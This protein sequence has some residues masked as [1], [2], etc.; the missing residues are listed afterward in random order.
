MVLNEGDF[1]KVEYRAWR[2][3]DNALVYTTDVEEAKKAGIFDENVTYGPHLV[4]VGKG[5]V[6]K[7]IDAAMRDMDVGQTKKI[8]LEPKDAF[9]ERNPNL[10]RVLPVSDL[11]RRD[12]NPYVGMTLDVDGVMATVKSITSGRVVIDANHRFAGEKMIYEVKIVEKEETDEKK[13]A[14]LTE[15][16]EVKQSS[17]AVN[18]DS[19]KI[20]VKSGANRFD[21]RYFVGKE[22]LVKDL[23][24]YFGRINKV[25]IEE[26]H[27]RSDVE[28]ESEQKQ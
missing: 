27:N 20:L 2:A 14:A 3:A 1:V 6:L 28:K 26:E 10:V 24:K 16:H 9:G 25:I 22:D 7:G 23:M 13:I 12:I 17:V 21:A 8:E 15:Y 19:V 11:K 4:I 18:A 5:M